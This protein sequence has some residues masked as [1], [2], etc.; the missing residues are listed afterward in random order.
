[1]IRPICTSVYS[2]KAAYTSHKRENNFFSSALNVFHG[3]TASAGF[4][5]FAGIGFHSVSVV[6]F[7]KIPFSIIL[8][9]TH[10]R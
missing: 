1:M 3:R 2:E 9:I 6:P 5:I 10:L 4:A 8:G 7:G